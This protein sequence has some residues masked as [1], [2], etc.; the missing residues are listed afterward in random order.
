[1]RTTGWELSPLVLGSLKGKMTLQTK[2]HFIGSLL[3][4]LLTVSQVATRLSDVLNPDLWNPNPAENDKLSWWDAIRHAYVSD[5]DHA[6]RLVNTL[7]V[8]DYRA[9]EMRWQCHIAFAAGDLAKARSSPMKHRGQ[10][11]A[12]LGF[13]KWTVPN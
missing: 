3:G 7:P 5:L 6:Q 11:S 1:M 12:H 10:R 4:E 2:A 8:P 9:V 13:G